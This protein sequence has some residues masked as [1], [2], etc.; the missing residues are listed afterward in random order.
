MKI[1]LVVFPVLKII[2]TVRIFEFLIAKA[3]NMYGE[4]GNVMEA[5]RRKNA[6]RTLLFRVFQ[7]KEPSFKPFLNE[8]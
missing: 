8:K 4:T 3:K 5:K 7:P 6:L 2:F 1:F